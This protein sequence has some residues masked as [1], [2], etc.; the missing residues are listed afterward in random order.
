MKTKK[1]YWLTLLL[2]A[3]V[4]FLLGLNTGV[5]VFNL[6][7]IGISF[8][9]YRNGYDVLFKEYD[10]SQKEKR[11]TAEKIY[12]ALREGKKKGE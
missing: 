1:A 10:D 12:A 4:L 11:E 3:V 6:L 9:V 5:Y 7:A 2:V 8:L